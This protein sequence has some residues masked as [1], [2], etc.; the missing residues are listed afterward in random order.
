MKEC[1]HKHQ[2]SY[3]YTEVE[4]GYRD[5]VVIFVPVHNLLG[6]SIY[7][8]RSTSGH[9]RS[10]GSAAVEASQGSSAEVAHQ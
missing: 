9:L 2:R 6:F 10:L 3:L 8:L 5:P 7:Q 1:A 4:V